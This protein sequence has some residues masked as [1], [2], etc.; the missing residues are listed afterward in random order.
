MTVPPG[1]KVFLMDR[2]DITA[3]NVLSNLKNGKEVAPGTEIELNSIETCATFKNMME[4]IIF[5]KLKEMFPDNAFVKAIE[6]NIG[7]NRLYNAPVSN[8]RLSIDLSTADTSPV[9]QALYNQIQGDFM[10][11]ST[12][13][14]FANKLG[15][16]NYSIGDLIYLYNLI[17]YKDSFGQDS[18]TRL[19]ERTNIYNTDSLV[20]KFYEFIS[21]IDYNSTEIRQDNNG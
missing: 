4:Q 16:G 6:G 10:Q 11:I 5:P 21:N 2:G 14:D 19:F 13:K 8:Q 3:Y 12:N 15:I 1:G 9:T 20:N 18:F 7:K 17:T